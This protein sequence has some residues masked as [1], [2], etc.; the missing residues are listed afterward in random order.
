MIFSINFFQ[1]IAF[2][3]IGLYQNTNIVQ[4]QSL[5]TQ[6]ESAYQLHQPHKAAKLYQQSLKSDASGNDKALAAKQLAHIEGHLLNNI[7]QARYWITQGLKHK[8]NQSLLYQ[9]LADLERTHQQFT[10]GKTAAQMATKTVKSKMDAFLANVTLCRIILD[11]QWNRLQNKQALNKP[12][13]KMAQSI[14]ANIT[15]RTPTISNTF[16]LQLNLALLAQDRATLY[17]SW[18]GFFLLAKNDSPSR[19]LQE[20][21]DLV[22]NACSQPQNPSL[23]G[24]KSQQLFLGLF[25][26]KLFKS[27]QMSLVLYPLEAKY[28]NTE[29]KEA[30]AY[31]DFINQAQKTTFQFY[32]KMVSRKP[33]FGQLQQLILP[34]AQ[35]LWA[36]LQWLNKPKKFELEA[37]KAALEEK[38]GAQYAFG[39]TNGF[40]SFYGGHAVQDQTKSITQYGKKGAIRFISLDGIVGNDYTGWY[41]KH[42]RVGGWASKNKF[43]QLRPAYAMNGVPQWSRLT[44]AVVRKKYLDKMRQQM[45]EDEKL[46]AKNPYAYLP[47]LQKQVEY[48]ELQR[49]LRDVKSKSKQSSN[50]QLAFIKYLK[51]LIKEA[52]IF[53]HEG[54]HV[55]DKNISDQFS[56]ADLEYRAKLSE[57]ALSPYPK[58]MFIRQVMTHS[59]GNNS[60]HGQANLKVIKKLVQWMNQHAATIK[61]FNAK[62]PTLLQFN[63]LTDNQLKIALQSFDPLAPKKK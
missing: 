28:R 24:Q 10:A 61:G 49:I 29:V 37:F 33:Q 18:R 9:T 42:I 50:L 7:V 1:I 17:Q 55:I 36:Q 52:S 3:L 27:A 15:Q 19:T 11:E 34:L 41:R 14:I 45:N 57:V 23:N 31:L 12:E 6:A 56:S 5:M 16:K 30:L 46:A 43:V 21:H 26:S 60:S 8:H 53:I 13:I 62:R 47:G 38:F 4:A 2:V 58:Y 40:P 44:D 54:R 35:K 20:A 59:I 63:L 22:K 39:S 48:Q 25:K 32:A 51:K